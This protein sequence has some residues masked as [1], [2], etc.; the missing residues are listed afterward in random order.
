VRPQTPLY[1]RLIGFTAVRPYTRNLGQLTFE[2]VSVVRPYGVIKILR[3]SSP[4][5]DRSSLVDRISGPS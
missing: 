2:T 5:V 1:Q 3:I 4:P